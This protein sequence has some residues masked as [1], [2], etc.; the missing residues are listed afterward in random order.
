MTLK[1]D[2]SQLVYLTAYTWDDTGVP[3]KCFETDNNLDHAMLV[4]KVDDMFVWN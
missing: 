2:V 4:S 3:E 1:A